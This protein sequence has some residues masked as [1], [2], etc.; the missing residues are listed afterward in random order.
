[1]TGI[2]RYN[3][4][5]RWP[6]SRSCTLIDD[7]MHKIWHP[8]LVSDKNAV[9]GSSHVDEEANEQVVQLEQT[10]DGEKLGRHIP[11]EFKTSYKHGDMPSTW[12]ALWPTQLLYLAS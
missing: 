12:L 10:D 5:G 8:R 6:P 9:P 11:R 3:L 1:M 7:L 2:S 4:G